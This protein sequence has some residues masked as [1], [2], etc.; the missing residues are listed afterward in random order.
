MLAVVVVTLCLMMLAII[1]MAAASASA[2]AEAKARGDFLSSM[3]HEIRTPLNGIVG[4]NHLMQRE[5]SQSGQAEG[6]SWQIQLHGQLPAFAYQRYPSIC[7]S[8]RLEKSI[9]SSSRSHLRICW[10]WSNPLS[11]TARKKS[12]ICFTVEQDLNWPCL[13]GDEVR[14]EQILINILGNAV[15]FTPSGGTIGARSSDG[16]RSGTDYHNL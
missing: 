14:I 15:K 2:R 8:R 4:L 12:K 5:P 1:R 7:P 16:S 11:V 10:R 6:L 3:S 13:V 9:C